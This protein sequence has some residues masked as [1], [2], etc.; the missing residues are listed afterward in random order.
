[1][2]NGERTSEHPQVGALVAFY[3]GYGGYS[4]CSGTLV[5]P[6][7]ALTAA[8]CV[9]SAEDQARQGATILFYMAPDVYEQSG[10][11]GYAA[12]DEFEMHPSYSGSA[13]NDS[14]DLGLLHL[15]TPITAVD[16]LPVNTD[17]IAGWQGEIITFLG[18]G[19]TK[20][21]SLGGGGGGVK[22]VTNIPIYDSTEHVL[23]AYDSVQN[24]CSGDSGGGGIRQDQTTGQW[25]LVSVNSFVYAVQSGSTSC[26]GGG[27]GSARVDTAL[28]WIESYVPLDEVGF[29]APALDIDDP[30]YIDTGDPLDPYDNNLAVEE[31]GLFGCSQIPGSSSLWLAAMALGG[32]L[33]R[34]R[35]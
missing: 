1:M 21:D 27:S 24:L 7:W 34:R 12:A 30:M 5:H 18:Y 13:L 19:I 6:E 26:V 15:D 10:V 16:P 28:D 29:G 14:W 23:Y 25:E 17:D 31:P 33:I 20:D 2:V 11:V 22:R 35:D 9:E 8:H 4:F 3:E 32:L